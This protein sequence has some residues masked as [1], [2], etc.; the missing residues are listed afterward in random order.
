METNIKTYIF[1]ND[2]ITVKTLFSW[3]KIWLTKKEI[4]KLYGI[5]KS[6][7]KKELNNILIDS[8]L[9]IAENVVKIYNNKKNKKETYY[10][11][12]ILLLLWYKSKHYKET[13][14][15]VNTNKM[16]KKYSFKREHRKANVFKN[17]LNTLTPF[18]WVA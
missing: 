12:D 1:E 10:S 6:E 17:I 2:N 15:L 3:G 18:F 5:E 4:A 16:I 8:D 7:I 11:L 9:D 14:F 13:K